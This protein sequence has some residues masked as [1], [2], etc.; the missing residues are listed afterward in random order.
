[1]FSKKLKRSSTHLML[2]T[3]AL[4]RFLLF[5]TFISSPYFI[6]LIFIEYLNV[7]VLYSYITSVIGVLNSTT[8]LVIL[9]LMEL[10][11]TPFDLA[12]GESELVSGFNVEY[13]R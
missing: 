13:G 4:L 3:I 7:V 12:E 10:R 5:F 8:M 1:M 11:R 2:S 6:I 9:W